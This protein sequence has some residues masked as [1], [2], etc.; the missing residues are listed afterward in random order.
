MVIPPFP[1]PLQFNV[2]YTKP[3]ESK[4]TSGAGSIISE[5]VFIENP[6]RYLSKQQERGPF[7][8]MM[9]A[10]E[11]FLH[12]TYPSMLNNIFSKKSCKKF[13]SHTFFLFWRSTST[14]G[15]F[16]FNA[17]FIK[18]SIKSVLDHIF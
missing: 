6:P 9:F 15:S 12:K 3:E 13:L 11:S 1:M 17:C 10:K 2:E 7:S 16:T 18:I 4:D 8:N 5:G 14:F